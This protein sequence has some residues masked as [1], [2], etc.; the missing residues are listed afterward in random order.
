MPD[1]APVTIT[2]CPSNLV[3]APCLL[4]APRAVTVPRRRRLTAQRWPTL[5]LARGSE[6]QTLRPTDRAA[7]SLD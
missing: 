2:T 4:A 7:R 5:Q 6:P 3:I 1:A